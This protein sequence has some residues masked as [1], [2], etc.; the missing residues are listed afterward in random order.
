MSDDGVGR[1][2]CSKRRYE[3]ETGSVIQVC[4]GFRGRPNSCRP[5]V[6]PNLIPLLFLLC[7]CSALSVSL[8]RLSLGVEYLYVALFEW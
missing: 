7:F 8:R 6:V 2:A 3:D 5:Y 4:V 1:K